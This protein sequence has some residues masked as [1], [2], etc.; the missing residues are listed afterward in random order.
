M[1]FSTTSLTFGSTWFVDISILTGVRGYLLVVVI[2]IS[3]IAS[4]VEHLFIYLLAIC[5]PSWEKC[6]FRSSAYFLIVLFVWCWVVWVIYIVWTLTPCW[7][8]FFANIFSHLAGCFL[9]CC[10]FLLLCRRFLV[11][12]SPIHFLPLLPFFGGVKFMKLSYSYVGY[13]TE[14][15]KWTKTKTKNKKNS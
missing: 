15:N 12:Y 10:W 5:M 3:L 9:F 13:K 14:S 2:C 7:I 1:C 4:K 11:W 6:L 8:T